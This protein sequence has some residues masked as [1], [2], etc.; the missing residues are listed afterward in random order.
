MITA[1]LSSSSAWTDYFARADVPVLRRTKRTLGQLA[2]DIENT[3][4]RDVAAVAMRD[5]LMA[6]KLFAHIAERRSGRQLTDITTV[7][8]CV[9]MMGVPPFFRTFGQLQTVEDRLR[10]SIPALRGLLRV[11][12]RAR[13]ASNFAWDFAR[14]R[15]DL[16]IEEIAIAALLH[17]LAEMLVWCFAPTLALRIEALQA[18]NPHLRSRAAQRDVLGVEIHD[19]Q[20]AL[21]KRWHLP[22]L[23]VTMM[24]DDNASH[25]RVC[26]VAFAVS[27]A[28]HSARGW[29]DP[30]LPDD[31][32]NIARLLNTTPAFVQQQLESGRGLAS[33]R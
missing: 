20:L 9:F 7:E 11:M 27:L 23:L 21:A 32:Q 4:A 28:R 14:W 29:T 33:R 18:A 2:A 1:P 12:R 6:A 15:V 16:G 24:D 17:D 10:V 30:A 22:E 8:G 19:V 13:R 31:Y 26:N 5:P 3:S 25:P